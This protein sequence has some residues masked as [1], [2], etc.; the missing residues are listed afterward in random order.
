MARLVDTGD[1]DCT[2]SSDPAAYCSAPPADDDYSSCRL[3]IL[4]QT[5]RV[6]SRVG[7]ALRCALGRRKSIV[8]GFSGPQF[9]AHRI[10]TWIFVARDILEGLE[11]WVVVG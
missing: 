11:I 9:S 5:D 6:M 1:S 4:F 3:G 10:S 7:T 8:E 2:V